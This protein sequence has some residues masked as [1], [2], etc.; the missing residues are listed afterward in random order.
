MSA[1]PLPTPGPAPDTLLY[2]LAAAVHAAWCARMRRGGWTPGER[3]DEARRTHDALVPFEELG[4][5]DRSRTLKVVQLEGLEER[6]AAMVDYPR[7][8]DRPLTASEMHRGLRVRMAGCLPGTPA[9]LGTIIGW[10]T[11][12]STGGLELVRVRWQDGR[13]TEHAPLGC[14][15][16]RLEL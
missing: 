15:L 13:V 9:L 6:L 11:S 8:P 12:P 3:L 14:E 4:E 1:S 16:R 7:G 2:Q 5:Y 10:E